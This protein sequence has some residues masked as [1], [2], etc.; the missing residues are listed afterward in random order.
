VRVTVNAKGREA[1]NVVVAIT[2]RGPARRLVREGRIIDLSLTAFATLAD[3]D[4][5]LIPVKVERVDSR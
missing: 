2:D 1:R 4:L 5:G 3:P